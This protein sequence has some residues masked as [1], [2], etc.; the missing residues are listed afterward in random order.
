M[1]RKTFEEKLAEMV[2]E[3][4]NSQTSTQTTQTEPE[5]A[6]AP[7]PEPAPEPAPEP[8]ESERAA[9]EARQR[10][11]EEEARQRQERENHEAEMRTQQQQSIEAGRQSQ[12][13]NTQPQPQGDDDPIGA[14]LDSTNEIIRKR[15]QKQATSFERKLAENDEAW[16]KKFEEFAAKF[17]PKP[18]LKTR[19]DFPADK[20]GDDAYIRY[21]VQQQNDQDHAA[22]QAEAD[23]QAAIEAEARKKQEQEE[24]LIRQ[25]QDVFRGNVDAAFKGD[26]ERKAK[27]LQRVQYVS[28]KGFGE[29]LDMNPAASDYLLGNP[30]GPM[31]MERIMND[32]ECFKRV[33]PARP[34]SP[35]EQFYELKRIEGEVRNP[36]PQPQ[37]QDNVPEKLRHLAPNAPRVGRPGAQGTATSVDPMNDPKARR[38]LVRK[39]MGC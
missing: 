9:E 31:V 27:F 16:K 13:Q 19:A 30:N 12:E 24:A 20:G 25:R 33:F 21:L 39:L 38:D 32:M 17:T 26:D 15:L 2:E 5:P 1:A 11:E 23:K 3:E 10:R 34:L 18:E 4:K 35:M 37:P 29:L 6:P 14:A 8:S 22:R 28:Q 36:Q 7:D